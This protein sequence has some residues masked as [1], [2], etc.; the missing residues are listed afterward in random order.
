ME[1]DTETLKQ[2]LQTEISIWG[3]CEKKEF[4][5]LQKRLK[6]NKILKYNVLIVFFNVLILGLRNTIELKR[7]AKLSFI[8]SL[9][10]KEN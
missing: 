7:L 8:N 6:S 3:F 9:K 5:E 4:Q 10:S 2:S 1:Y